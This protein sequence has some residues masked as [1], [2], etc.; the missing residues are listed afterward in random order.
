MYLGMAIGGGLCFLQGVYPQMLYKLLPFPMT[1]EAPYFYQ[2]YTS[3]HVLQAMLLLSFTGLGF[4]LM[5]KRLKPE[6]KLNL[7]FDY[8][9]RLV[10]RA[11]LFVARY[12]IEAIDNWWTDVYRKAG[13]RGLLGMGWFTSVF[14]KQ[15]IDGV[16]DNSAYGVRGT[17]SILSR[18]QTGRLQDYV[19][20]LVVLGLLIFVVCW[21]VL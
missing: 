15:G 6:P 12:P 8:V 19:A 14:D 2:P 21:Y 18:V 5:N 16:L 13:L 11:A 10:G 17:G 4:Y 9:Y 7:D 20:G 3:W 1:A